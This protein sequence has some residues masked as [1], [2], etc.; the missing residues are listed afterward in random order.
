MKGI[1]YFQNLRN[2]LRNFLEYFWILGGIFWEEFFWRIFLG[3]S[4][5]GGF[6]GRIFLREFFEEDFFGRIF[7]EEFFGKN[8]LVEINKEL[9]FLSTFW[10]NARRRRRTKNLDP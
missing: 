7:W 10:G 8:Y 9:M 2:H 6:F 3:R 4:F 1:G 5:L